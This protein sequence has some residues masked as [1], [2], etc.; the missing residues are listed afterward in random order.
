MERSPSAVC[1]VRMHGTAPAHFYFDPKV[2]ENK[3]GFDLAPEP[4]TQHVTTN[5]KAV[6]VCHNDIQTF[7]DGAKSN[8]E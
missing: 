5:H 2:V 3:V 6:Q 8:V 7:I 4:Q 1:Y